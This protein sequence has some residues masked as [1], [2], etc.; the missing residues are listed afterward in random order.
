MP[1]NRMTGY[2]PV[3]QVYQIAQWVMFGGSLIRSMTRCKYATLARMARSGGDLPLRETAKLRTRLK[4]LIGW[5]LVRYSAP[6]RRY[7]LTADGWNLLVQTEQ[8]WA[9]EQE[10]KVQRTA[11]DRL[12]DL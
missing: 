6:C 3:S 2:A 8:A 4:V 12:G 7:E 5:G 11:W 1:T 9:L 10:K